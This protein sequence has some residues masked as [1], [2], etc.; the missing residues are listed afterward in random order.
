M[1]L[2]CFRSTLSR[3][4]GPARHGH[5]LGVGFGPGFW[6][7]SGIQDPR[8]IRITPYYELRLRGRGVHGKKLMKKVGRWHW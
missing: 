4:R 1:E 5:E 3:R 7:T 6:I 2:H 8:G